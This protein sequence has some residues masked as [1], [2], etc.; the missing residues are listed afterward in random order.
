M[1]TFEAEGLSGARHEKGQALRPRA[2]LEPDA[3]RARF[4]GQGLIWSQMRKGP[5]FEAEYLSARCEKKARV[6]GRELIWSQTQKKDRLPGQGLSWSQARNG[7]G[8]EAERLSGARREKGQASRPR[9]C[10]E[11]DAKR[12]TL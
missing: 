2:Y 5:N 9:A 6:R 1:K 10:L 8:F 11:P 12:A 7:P 3:K 4:C